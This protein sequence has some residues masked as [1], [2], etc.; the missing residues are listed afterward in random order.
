[1]L[2]AFRA[3]VNACFCQSSFMRHSALAAGLR[4]L[5]VVLAALPA[6]S[7]AT[8]EEASLGPGALSG[9]AGGAAGALGSAGSSG[10]AMNSKAGGSGSSAASA[11]APGT[12]AG[13]GSTGA[14]VGGSSAGGASAGIGGT[15][16]SSGGKAGSASG[17]GKAGASSGGSASGGAPNG[18]APNGGAPNGGAPSGGGKAGA[19]SGGAPSGGAP[20][21]GAPSGGAPSGGAPSG[22]AC[23][24]AHAVATLGTSQSYTGKAND[25]I[26]LAVQPSWSTVSLQLQ[27]LAGTAAYPVPFSFFSCAGNGTGALTADYVNAVIK[28][29]ANP[30]CDYFVQ[31]GGGATTIK[32]TYFD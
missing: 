32:V 30:G 24:A 17:G 9:E 4:W 19:P 12:P 11:G 7:C 14:A 10:A 20:S 6:W 15:A 22:G 23:D 26:R 31:F 1:M 16:G 3:V 13:A 29:G 2:R 25:C 5:W 27:P 8:A 28:S 18:G 21:G